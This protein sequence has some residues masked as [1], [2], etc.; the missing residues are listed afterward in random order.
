MRF[1][2]G[3]RVDAV[4][5]AKHDLFAA[6]DY[7]VLARHGVL[8]VRD[9]LRW[10]R[11]ERRPGFYDWSSFLPMLRAAN[12]AGVE[13]IWDLCH[14]GL[15][16]GVDPWSGDLVERFAAYAAAAAR[17]VADEGGP[18]PTWCPVNEI[19]YWAFAAG[20]RTDFEPFGDGRGRAWKRQLVRLATTG[21]RA[22]REVDPRARL[23]HIDPV[24]HIA[25]RDAA[26]RDRAERGR[27]SMFEAWDM[28]TGRRD[29]D[30]G[31]SPNLLDILG[32]NFYANNEWIDHGPVLFP[33]DPS[34]R[35]L[36]AILGEVFA[37]YGRP[38]VVA[39]TGAE[40]PAGAGWLRT[41]CD[42]ALAAR[43]AGV[44]VAGLCVYPV[45]DY[46]GWTDDRHCRCGLIETSSDWS[47]RRVDPAM[48]DA[49]RAVQARLNP[50]SRADQLSR[51]RTSPSA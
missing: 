15:P 24:I 1:A 20:E 51:V 35:P 23:M 34:Y 32:V 16:D 25:S 7:A 48:A 39:E 28:I 3:R 43:E 19:S 46:P 45:M 10:H 42:E 22:I 18:A 50:S 40:G 8:T 9:T 11:I 36:R 21:S 38:I 17:V 2:S 12:R 41:A 33:G 13:V 14:F 44:P 6:E 31:G 37:R 26:G 29:P 27:R 49:V 5:D 47:G 30:L 4:A